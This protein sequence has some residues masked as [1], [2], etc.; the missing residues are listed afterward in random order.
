MSIKNEHYKSLLK[1]L[2]NI[3]YPNI[4]STGKIYEKLL[5]R[6]I[7]Y[8]MLNK[9]NKYFS[10]NKSVND[11]TKSI[12]DDFD[13]LINNET[14]Y[15]KSYF[16]SNNEMMNISNQLR[17]SIQ[18]YK[19]KNTNSLTCNGTFQSVN[20]IKANH[21]NIFKNKIK[22]NSILPI[23]NYQ[24]NYNSIDKHIPYYKLKPLTKSKNSILNHSEIKQKF[25]KKINKKKNLI[26]NRYNNIHVMSF[27]KYSIRPDLIKNKNKNDSYVDYKIIKNISVPNFR[28]MISREKK[29]LNKPLEHARDYTPNYNAIYCDKTNLPIVNTELKRKKNLLRK[30]LVNYHPRAE[31]LITPK[32]NII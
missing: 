6:N 27:D 16:N 20:Q 31:Y 14:I 24:P 30:I 3:K 25:F 7:F 1:E 18:K 19:E 21:S 15:H 9:K 11:K 23:S 8:C 5:T 29:N 4:S 17:Y 32:L 26:M 2:K 28:K 12:E 10:R 22:K 13:N